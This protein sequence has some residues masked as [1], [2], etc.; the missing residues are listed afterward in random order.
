MKNN[1]NRNKN[2]HCNI[3]KAEKKIR[4]HLEIIFVE[5]FP[6]RCHLDLASGTMDKG[7][8]NSKVQY[9]ILLKIKKIVTL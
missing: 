7:D 2:E 6:N 8:T 3:D 4:Q 9:L 1:F 5:W